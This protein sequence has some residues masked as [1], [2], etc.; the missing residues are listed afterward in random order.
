MIVL[1]LIKSDGSNISVFCFFFHRL[2]KVAFIKI[3]ATLLL[4]SKLNSTKT[5]N[6]AFIVLTLLVRL[7]R[8]KIK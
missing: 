6:W 8:I 1:A 4:S 5:D 2:N 7:Q 3:L